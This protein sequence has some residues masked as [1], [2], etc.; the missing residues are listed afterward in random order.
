MT[1]LPEAVLTAGAIGASPSVGSD[2]TSVSPAQSTFAPSKSSLK[3]KISVTKNTT[4][5]DEIPN[6]WSPVSPL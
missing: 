4:S 2:D 5:S 6:P 3:L 1:V